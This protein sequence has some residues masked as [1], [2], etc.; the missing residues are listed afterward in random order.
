MREYGGRF[1]LSNNLLF[2]FDK[3]RSKKAEECT[4]PASIIPKV[5]LVSLTVL[6]SAVLAVINIEGIKK[7]KE[8]H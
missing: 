6:V 3:S 4:K 1:T 5:V 2:R 7:M 8:E